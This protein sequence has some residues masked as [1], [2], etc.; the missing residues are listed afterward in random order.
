MLQSIK[1]FLSMKISRLKLLV[2]SRKCLYAQLKPP[3]EQ[4]KWPI[5]AYFQ[6]K[7]ESRAPKKIPRPPPP[8]PLGFS[9][10]ITIYLLLSFHHPEANGKL[11][12]TSG[13]L[14]VRTTFRLITTPQTSPRPRTSDRPRRRKRPKPQKSSPSPETTR[15]RRMK[16]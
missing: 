14:K 16:P 1:S 13:E 4:L 7:H 5:S 10:T 11:F 15:T 6:Q 2:G 3:Y 12:S 8:G 9:K